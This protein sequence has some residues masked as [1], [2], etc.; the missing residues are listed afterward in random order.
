[1][2]ETVDPENNDDIHIVTNEEIGD[3][4]KILSDEVN[5]LN[6]KINRLA[7][8]FQSHEH[9]SNGLVVF[10]DGSELWEAV[11]GRVDEE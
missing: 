4:I 8:L 7:K 10:R 6:K 2:E 3:A 9:K 11:N 5:D 1:M